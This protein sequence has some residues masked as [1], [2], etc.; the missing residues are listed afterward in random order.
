M[1]LSHFKEK[2]NEDEREQLTLSFK[3]TLASLLFILSF[4]S[5]ES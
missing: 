4:F 5:S 2:E 1:F 3:K